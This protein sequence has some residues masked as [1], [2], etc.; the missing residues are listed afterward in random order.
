MKNNITATLK[1]DESESEK[2]AFSSFAFPTDIST[3]LIKEHNS[4]IKEGD[5]AKNVYK[6]AI[7]AF[8]EFESTY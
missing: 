1:K 6:Q 3:S 8:E 4:L 2:Y 5:R 7:I